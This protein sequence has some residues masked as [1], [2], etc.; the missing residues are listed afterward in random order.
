MDVL[1]LEF[2]SRFADNDLDELLGTAHSCNL[3]V[4][5]PVDLLKPQ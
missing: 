2:L 1:K 4:F 3:L 5:S